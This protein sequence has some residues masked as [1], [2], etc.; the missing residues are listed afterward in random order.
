MKTPTPSEILLAALRKI[1][2][3][4]EQGEGHEHAWVKRFYIAA[5]D[6][7]KPMHVVTPIFDNQDELEAYCANVLAYSIQNVAIAAGE[8]F[9]FEP[10]HAL[11]TNIAIGFL[12]ER[13]EGSEPFFP[14]TEDDAQI[15]FDDGSPF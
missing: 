1:F 12:E 2:E 7:G 14:F 3:N 5:W 15:D 8:D 11:T 4:A 13:P 10:D 9:K 6:D